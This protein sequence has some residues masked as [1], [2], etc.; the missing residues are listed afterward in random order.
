MPD[1]MIYTCAAAWAGPRHCSI[2][3]DLS[4]PVYP[5]S[6]LPQGDSTAPASMIATLAPWQPPG[7]SSCYMDDRSLVADSAQ[8]L[9]RDLK[10]TTDFDDNV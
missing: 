5:T 4:S 8:S 6:G 3:N 7:G 10:L 9:Q 1:M 2:A